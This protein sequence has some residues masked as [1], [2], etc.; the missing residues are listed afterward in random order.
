M[1]ICLVSLDFKPFRSSGLTIYAE[2]LAR[3]LREREHQVIV[4]AALRRVLPEQHQVEGVEV[5]RIEPGS[6]DWIT[7]CRNAAK[8][9]QQLEQRQPFDVIHFLDVH[10]AYTYSGPY[11][12]SLWQSFRQRLTADGGKPYHTTRLDMIKRQVYYCLARQWMERP[13]LSRAGRLLASCQSTRAEFVSAYCI[14]PEKVDLGVQGINTDVFHPLPGNELRHRLGLEKAFVLLFVGFMNPRKGLEYLARAMNQLP[15]HVYL[16]LVG[17]W[18]TGY[19]ARV[20]R[21]FGEACHRVYEAGFLPDEDLPAFYSMADLYVS[22]SLLEGLGV[23]P[24][25]AMACG[26]PAIVTDASS[27]LE[28][29]GEARL[30]VPA[31]NVQAL[32]ERIL[33][34]VHHPRE[35]ALLQETCRL[36]VVQLF[37]YQRMTDLTLESYAR[38]LNQDLQ[39]RRQKSLQISEV[40]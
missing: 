2:D 8:H 19:R 26:T 13:A 34:F 30:V 17:R 4:L 21:A 35:L 37:S 22:P 23:T 10:F 6:L 39:D 25:E 20:F 9:L 28:E 27:G 16:I 36:R 24:I 14:P 38:F 31:R 1:R 3:G 7:Y 29:V 33:W 32:V 40:R 18:A 12:A 5:Y 15:E 11:F